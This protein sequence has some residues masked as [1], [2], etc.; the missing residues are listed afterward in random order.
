MIFLPKKVDGLADFEKTLSAENVAG[1][2][3]KLRPFEVDVQLK[4]ALGSTDIH[5]RGSPVNLAINPNMVS[6]FPIDEDNV[7]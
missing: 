5:D 4:L 2:L 3:R 6:V 1:W 7:G